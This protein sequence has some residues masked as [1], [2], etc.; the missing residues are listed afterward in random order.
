M[1]P[2]LAQLA[3]QR[4]YLSQ[5]LSKVRR[6]SIQATGRGDFRG[7]AKLTIEAARINRAIAETQDQELLAL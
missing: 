4:E 2:N 5:E 7:V 1:N 6:H 3:R